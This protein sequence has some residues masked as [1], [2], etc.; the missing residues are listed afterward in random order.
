L[1]QNRPHGVFSVAACSDKCSSATAGEDGTRVDFAMNI[2]R[3]VGVVPESVNAREILLPASS[4]CTAGGCPTGAAQD[5]VATRT[6]VPHLRLC[7][8][9]RTMTAL[10]CLC[11]WKRPGYKFNGKSV[12]LGK[13]KLRVDST[14]SRQNPVEA[15]DKHFEKLSVPVK[16]G[17][18]FCS[19]ATIKLL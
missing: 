10:A 4:Y 5:T 9:S 17:N 8:N 1:F 15:Y 11:R 3:K 12:I 2:W 7:G 14:G 19:Y 16:A 6:A 13:Y 18:F